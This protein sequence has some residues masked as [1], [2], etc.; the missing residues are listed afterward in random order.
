MEVPLM[1]VLLRVH[2][3]LSNLTYKIKL[4]CFK[5]NLRRKKLKIKHN[6]FRT[7]WLL[8]SS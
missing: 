5:L 2:L 7:K 3:Q 8:C 1:E 4:I 6:W